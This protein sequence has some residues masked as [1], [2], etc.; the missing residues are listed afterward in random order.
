MKPPTSVAGAAENRVVWLETSQF[1]IKQSFLK[2]E[3]QRDPEFFER[4]YAAEF[5]DS[6]TSAFGR[7]AVEACKVSGRFEL[8]YCHQFR[9]L[10]AVD[11]AGGGPDEFALAI[12]H[13]EVSGKVVPIPA[14]GCQHF[15]MA[16]Y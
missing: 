7:E 9:Y 2:G 3:K 14:K 16:Q 11:P 8:P 4:E 12:C 6:I 13:R 15:W 1:T 5:S 10:A